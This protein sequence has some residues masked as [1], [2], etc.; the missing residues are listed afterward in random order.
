MGKIHFAKFANK[1]DASKFA[2]QVILELFGNT[3][4]KGT[5]IL[6]TATGQTPVLTYEAMRYLIKTTHY[7][8]LKKYY[9]HLIMRQLD[10][11]ISPGATEYNLPEYSYELELKKSIWQIPNGG[12]FIPREWAKDPEAEAKRY[13]DIIRKT[14][15]EAAY[16]LQILGIGDEDGHIAFNMPGDSFDCGVHVVNLNEETIR[17]NADKF[18]N[19]DISRVPRRAITTGIGDILE[20]DLII[21]EAFGKKK[22]DIIWKSFFSTAPTTDIPATALQ[23]FK[24]TLLVILDKESASKIVEKE[25]EKV[26]TTYS[27]DAVNEFAKELY[28]E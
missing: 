21:L 23:S 7:W 16:I 27:L 25:G 11:Y 13:K 20:S 12:T 3:G 1:A 26:F 5:M 10:N 9:K 14:N 28:N 19:G 8:W 4:K 22:A 17:A 24:G 18:F 2:A 6:G 15:E